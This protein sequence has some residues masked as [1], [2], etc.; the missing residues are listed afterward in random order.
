MPRRAHPNHPRAYSTLT[1]ED[2]LKAEHAKKRLRSARF[3]QQNAM[4]T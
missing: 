2:N 4:T 3:Q 1:T